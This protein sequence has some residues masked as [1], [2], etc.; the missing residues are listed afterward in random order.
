MR[1]ASHH[2]PEEFSIESDQ[3][4]MGL[5]KL[6][7]DSLTVSFVGLTG[8]EEQKWLS[9]CSEGRDFSDSESFRR[10]QS[11]PSVDP[12]NFLILPVSWPPGGILGYLYLFCEDP[13][14]MDKS[15]KAEQSV[16]FAD[17]IAQR[18]NSSK[19][20]N[21]AGE[22][23][24]Q[25]QSEI[26]YLERENSQYQH[27]STHTLKEPLRKLQLY[28]NLIEEE[29]RSGNLKKAS[30]L[31]V[32]VQRFALQFAR[33]IEDVSRFADLKPAALKLEKVDLNAIVLTVCSQ[34]T[35]Q[36]QQKEAWVEKDALPQIDAV[37]LLMAQLFFE[38]IR[39]S[40]W[41]SKKQVAPVIKISSTNDTSD[42][43][44]VIVSVSDNGIGIADYHLEKVFDVFE[45]F[46]P[47]EALPG[48][49]IGLSYCQKIAH[50][51]GGSISAESILGEGTQFFI[52]LP[53]RKSCLNELAIKQYFF[54]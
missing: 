44:Y 23:L 22:L 14:L 12:G 43:D 20:L 48:R 46:H 32:K 51:H 52:R 25:K 42:S 29:A 36:I 18:I 35:Q 3:Q 4:M 6:V 7:C 1:N 37:P 27:I 39:N 50:Y 40:L 24:R 34:M 38:L 31:A 28:S 11:S 21:S 30:E 54:E 10:Y 49:G 53:V 47:E 26:N 19:Q 13:L 8:V 15:V 9:H 33:L 17:L 2:I 16:K 41:F 5:L 45:R